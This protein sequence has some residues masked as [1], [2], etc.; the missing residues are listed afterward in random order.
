MEKNLEEFID[1]SQII[2][3]VYENL[4]DYN[5]TKKKKVLIKFDDMIRDIEYDKKFIPFV[6]EFI[7]EDT[8][9]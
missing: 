4:E 5:S 6:T 8:K 2:D 1:Y 7:I 3:G 9:F